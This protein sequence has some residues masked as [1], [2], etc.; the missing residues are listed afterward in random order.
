MRIATSSGCG[1]SSTSPEKALR[2]R[3]RSSSE[4]Q[5]GTTSTNRNSAARSS[6]SRDASSIA[7]SSRALIGCRAWDGY[8]SASR[9]PISWI[10][11]SSEPS[12]P[13][14]DD[15]PRRYRRALVCRAETSSRTEAHEHGNTITRTA[16]R[17]PHARRDHAARNRL[18]GLEDSSERG[19]AGPLLGAREARARSTRAALRERLG[20]HPRSARDFFDALVALGMLE[21]DN[22]TYSQHD[23]DRPLPRPRQAELYRRHAR[24]DERAALRLLE[25][26]DRGP[27]H[28]RAPE[29][30][31]GRRG[32]FRRALHGSREAARIRQ[33]DDRHQHGHR[34]WRSPRAF[35]GTATR[36]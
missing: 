19:R 14:P 17:H 1:R 25:L 30:G 11:L 21:R 32:P 28:R 24:D 5:A 20:L 4:R 12:S 9:A 8:A 23:R 33:G 15:T 34:A 2:C 7:F 27:A 16:G 29:R 36:P 35:P 3:A 13:I 31:E 6:A 10:A 26:A 22:G 18:L